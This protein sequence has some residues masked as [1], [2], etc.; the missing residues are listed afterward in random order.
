MR[1]LRL[2]ALSLAFSTV[3]MVSGCRFIRPLAVK[4]FPGTLKS[5]PQ[6]NPSPLPVK[7]TPP[8]IRL[9][10]L[11]GREDPFVPLPEEFIPSEGVP[12][13]MPE[14]IIPPDGDELPPSIPQA[15]LRGIVLGDPPLAYIDEGSGAL[16]RITLGDEVLGGLVVLIADRYIVI[17][18]ANKREFTLRL[19]ESP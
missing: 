4:S 1:P 2:I 6:E 9:Q 15:N 7:T 8:A 18:E 17:R 11:D 16:R 12:R 14:L 3:L 5:S 13:E 19:E 10:T